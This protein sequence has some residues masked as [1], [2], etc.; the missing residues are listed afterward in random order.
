MVYDTIRKDT[1]RDNS[2]SLSRSS[3]PKA[4]SE[5]EKRHIL[6]K[7]KCGLFITYCELRDATSILISNTSFLRIFKESG[8]EHWKVQK[9]LK[10]TAG[11]AK[12]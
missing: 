1:L 9:Q 8:Y 6:I 10:L 4:V 12:L 5:R 3:R 11:Y 7:I 2:E